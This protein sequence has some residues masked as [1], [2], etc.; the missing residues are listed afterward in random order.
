MAETSKPKAF[1]LI[2]NE[3]EKPTTEDYFGIL[4]ALSF[5]GDVERATLTIEMQEGFRMTFDVDNALARRQEE[6]Q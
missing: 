6:D 4:V 3:S 2:I 1:D 5:I